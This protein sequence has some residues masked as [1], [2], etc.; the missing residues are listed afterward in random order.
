MF[1]LSPILQKSKSKRLTVTLVSAAQTGYLYA[2][3]KSPQKAEFRMALRK[4][5]PIVNQH[6]MFYETKLPVWRRQIKRA[7]ERRH[8]RATGDR[9]QELIQRVT[10][11]SRARP[12]AKFNKGGQPTMPNKV[13]SFA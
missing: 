1:T 5:D 13:G 11:G 6:V 9:M 4:Y 8:A 12:A 7:I 2:T 3:T 10:K